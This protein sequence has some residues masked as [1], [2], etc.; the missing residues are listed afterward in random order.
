MRKIREIL[1]KRWHLGLS[2]N[3]IS[4]SIR[5]SPTTVADCLGRA[6]LARLSW[7]LPEGMDDSAL[8]A[9]LYPTQPPARQA[10]EVPDWNRIYRELRRKGVTLQLL[11]YEY[12]TNHPDDGYQYSQFCEHYRRF[13]GQL[14]VVMRQEYRA[15]EKGFMDFSGDGI[16]IVDPETGEVTQGELFVAVLGASNYTYAEVFPS[17]ALRS[18][19]DGHIHAY[20]Y[21]EGVPEI[22]VP[23]NPKTAVVRPCWYDPD[24]NP[25]YRDMGRHYDTA[26]IPA[27][28]R[29]PR[30]KAKVE[31]G[32]LVAQ[33]WIIAKLRNHTFFSIEQANEA[34]RRELEEL[35]G[36]KLQKLDCSRREL[37]ETVERP[38]LKPLPTARFVFADWSSPRVNI[39]YHVEIDKHYYSVPHTLVHKKV[40]ARVTTSTVEIFFKNQRV[41][42]HVRSYLKGQHTTL[43][44]HMPEAHRRYAEWS[45]SRVLSWAAKVG[46]ATACLAERIMETRQHPQQ[47]YRACL[48]LIRLAK[49][50]G[51]DRMEAASTRALAFGAYSYRS[52]ESIL[53]RGMDRQPLPEET[54]PISPSMHENVRG[55]ESYH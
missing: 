2:N 38:A 24:L 13:R 40:E 21:F 1:E 32:V 42:S 46:P 29:K 33:R 55:P 31:A 22:S 7:P 14:D 9:L 39:D 15:G 6:T 48:G 52:V 3:A 37:W 27:R 20:E 35:N 18:W 30:D 43:P 17:Q 23:D 10:R 44:E 45:P 12:K 34:V 26:I 47:G 19:V 50:H 41:A 4:L 28:P 25:T 54:A 16:P 8:E 5:V 49:V 11:W 51:N 53:K 36:R